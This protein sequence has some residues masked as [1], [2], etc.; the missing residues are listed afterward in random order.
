MRAVIATTGITLALNVI[1]AVFT[2]AILGLFAS[3]RKWVRRELVDP[4]QE[5]KA[6]FKREKAKRRRF[7]R[8]VVTRMRKYEEKADIER[9]AQVTE[10][11]RA[12]AD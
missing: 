5:L 6:D 12:Q 8:K 11:A 3:G 1:S 2:A 9:R 7:Q 10:R 4:V